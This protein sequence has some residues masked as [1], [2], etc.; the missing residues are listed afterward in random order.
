MHQTIVGFSFNKMFI[1]NQCNSD[2]SHLTISHQRTTH[3]SPIF[4]LR[5]SSFTKAATYVSYC[6]FT[7]IPPHQNS[8]MINSPKCY[9][10]KIL[11]YTVYS[12]Q[13]VPIF[14]IYGWNNN[15]QLIGYLVICEQEWCTA[16][17]VRATQFYVD[18]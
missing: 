2:H 18:M 6:K 3:H 11:R 9:P 5:N 4:T 16:I 14:L 7:N 10:A 15:V 8:K 13:T 12:A 17:L 1:T